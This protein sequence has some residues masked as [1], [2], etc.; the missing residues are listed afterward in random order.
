MPGVPP[1]GTGNPVPSHRTLS[2]K[3]NPQEG[4]GGLLWFF[5]RFLQKHG[6]PSAQIG[7]EEP[8]NTCRM[9]LSGLPPLPTDRTQISVTVR[10]QGVSPLGIWGGRTPAGGDCVARGPR[11][12]LR[13]LSLLPPEG[14]FSGG[15]LPFLYFK[16][17]ELASSF[18]GLGWNGHVGDTGPPVW[19]WLSPLR[20]SGPIWG[21]CGHGGMGRVSGR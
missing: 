12:R 9:A 14:M 18:L 17:C 4:D 8:C 6:R 19:T 20:L 3:E 10:N 7:R 11:H 5:L 21:R 13:R 15:F 1:E 2:A 16:L